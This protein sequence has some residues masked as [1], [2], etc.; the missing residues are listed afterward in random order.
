[1]ITDPMIWDSDFEFPLQLGF[2]I[3]RFSARYWVSQISTMF[4]Q[5]QVGLSL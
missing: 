3:K 1:M 4:W 5:S 2:Y